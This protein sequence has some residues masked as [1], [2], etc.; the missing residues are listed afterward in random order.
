M[1]SSS[2]EPVVD[3]PQ[4]EPIK[5]S[6]VSTPENSLQEAEGTHL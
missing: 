2:Q 1:T 6:E 5:P 3:I 4:V